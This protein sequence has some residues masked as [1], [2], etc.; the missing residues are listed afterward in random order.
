MGSGR[1][2][3]MAGLA[4]NAFAASN[5]DVFDFGL[6]AILDGTQALLDARAPRHAAQARQR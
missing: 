4:E 5:E 6:R 3:N 1:Y 2:P